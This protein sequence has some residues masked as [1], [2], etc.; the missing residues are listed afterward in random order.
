MRRPSLYSSSTPRKS[1]PAGEA[2]AQQPAAADKPARAARWSAASPRLLW[3]AISLL[4]VLLV[5]A[6]ALGVRPGERRLTQKDIDAAV[7]KTLE[8]TTLP[9]AAARAAEAIRPSVVRVVSYV[10]KSRLKEEA[11][12]M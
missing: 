5:A 12:R 10:K 1:A 9:S 7:L 6:V 3:S 8:T 4:L 2:A 11:E